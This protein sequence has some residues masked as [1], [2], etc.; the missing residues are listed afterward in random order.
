MQMEKN[1]IKTKSKS[2]TK[3]VLP[4][5]LLAML[6]W[7]AV[8]QNA[9]FKKTIA[10]YKN[11]KVV[12]ATATKT[13]HRAALTNDV[14]TKGTLTMKAPNQVSII[15]GE[16]KD[17]L[18]MQGDTFTMVVKGKKHVTDSKKNAMFLSF[19]TVFESILTGGAKDISHLT[20]LNIAKQGSNWVLTIAP[21]VTNKQARR[22]MFTS[23]VLTIDAQTSELR[24]LRMN[25]KKGNYTEYT[26]NH[27]VFK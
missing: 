17:Q 13:T 9:E 12:T 27:F 19:Q 7:S 15:I 1:M 4:F 2:W 25:E 16:G 18:L 6:P 8:A 11:Y 26:F 3:W 22:M 23:F 20:D 24:A 10:S 21:Q 14:V 5:L